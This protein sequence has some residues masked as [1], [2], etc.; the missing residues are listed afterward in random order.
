MDS[1]W[2]VLKQRRADEAITRR[3]R[4]AEGLQKAGEDLAACKTIEEVAEVAA[5]APVERLNI[6]MAFVA[7][8]GPDGQ[9][10]PFTYSGPEL[11]QAL[12]HY[13]CSGEVFLR[14]RPEL[15]LDAVGSPPYPSC[16]DVARCHEFRSCGTFPITV[17]D[18]CVATLTLRFADGGPDG[19]LMEALPLIGV[20]CRQVGSVWQRSL[21][22]R[23][24]NQALYDTQE[25]RDRI[26]GIL[27]SIAD[28]L[29]VTD[30][31]NRVILMNRAAEDLLDVR[32][33]EVLD[34]PIDFAIQDKTLRE[35]IKT[36]LNE[37]EPGYQFDFELPGD[38]PKRPRIMRAR[39]SGIIDRGG[40]QRG[41]VTIIHDVTHEREV[42]RMKTEFLSTAAHELRTPLTS[43][44]GFS[45]ILLTRDNITRK[46][47]KRYLRYINDQSE[48][49]TTI[50]NDLLD[51][52][53]I[54]S[55]RGFTVNKVKCMAGEVLR[56]GIPYFHGIS[57]Q[58]TIEVVVPEEPVELSV[59][60]EKM[61]QVLK[62]LVSNAIKYSPE[63]GA[64][65][66]VGEVFEDCYRVSVE[67]E[68]IGMTPE[69]VERV[70]D[71]FYRANGSDSAPEGTGL[72][73]TIV[74]YI[75][76]AHGG[77]VWVESE[78]GQGTTVRVTIPR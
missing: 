11:E 36:S 67:D 9:V 1:M 7:A 55:G 33:S 34:R 22:E 17:G 3:A 65:R 38:D 53:R 6:R 71:K 63:G 13:E 30:I 64:I 74:K 43:I 60:K 32:F 40:Q 31:Y 23:K 59:D 49:L 78:L 58:H 15:V 61:E 8:P 57:P 73:M 21:A 16:S 12:V 41:I 75:V 27:K 2:G 52:S 56:E 45:E 72:G 37:R 54:E 44:R 35:R 46:E 51:I 20:F 77:T 29:I 69:Q 48:N 5:R 76:E 28:G 50:I 62:N 39:T 47:R 4:W 68:G 42:D 10:R 70:F 14:G 24:L 18:E 25:A 66:V 19:S 26:D